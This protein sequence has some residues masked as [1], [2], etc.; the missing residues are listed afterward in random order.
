VFEY[1]Q[2]ATAVLQGAAVMETIHAILGIVPGPAMPNF[3]QWAGRTNMILSVIRN[4][5]PLQTS[6][7]VAILLFAWTLSE[8]IRYP[9]YIS[10]VLKFSPYWLTWLRYT[11]FIPLYPIGITCEVMTMYRALPVFQKLYLKYM[12]MFG[13]PLNKV[14]NPFNIE[15]TDDITYNTIMKVRKGA[16]SISVHT[17]HVILTTV[18]NA[19]RRF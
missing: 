4:V 16:F 14:L 13:S 5:P 17:I 7:P 12:E 19:C 3:L 9:W 8:V 6:I 2:I 10:H 11:A 18:E 15:L 1:L